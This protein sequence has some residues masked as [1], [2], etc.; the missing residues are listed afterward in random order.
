MTG[1]FRMLGKNGLESYEATIRDG[2]LKADPIEPRTDRLLVPGFVDLHIHGAFGVDF[3]AATG[4]QMLELADRLEQIGYEAFLPTTV[5]ASAIDVERA[6]ANLP[7]DPRMPGFHLEGPFISDLFPG[8]QPSEAIIDPPVQAEKGT[9]W[10]RILGDP[11]LRVITLAPERPG[12]LSLASNLSS[13]GAIL[14]M[15]HTNASYSEAQL[16]FEHG[17]RHATHVF[18]AMR[19]LHHREPGAL[20]F[21][22]LEDRLSAEIIYDRRHV[23]PE[24]ARLLLR[25]KPPDKIVAVSDGT[26]ASGSPEGS[27]FEMWGLRVETRAGSVYI[28]GA[29]TLAGSSITLLDAFRNLAEDFGPETAIRLCCLNPRSA[30]AMTSP[31]RLWLEFDDAFH[32]CKVHK[33]DAV[34]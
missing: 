2:T 3:M 21:A 25:C 31:P 13:G 26:M 18:N 34:P 16:G 28:E 12:A 32:L 23:S 9:P 19:G 14:S 30:L 10:Q 33:V 15:G 4:P 6:I 8:A 7:D 24:A 22:L 20:G 27:K 29:D 5:S 1:I 17:F 11:R